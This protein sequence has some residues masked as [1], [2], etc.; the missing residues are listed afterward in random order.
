MTGETFDFMLTGTCLD[1]NSRNCMKCGFPSPSIC[2]MTEI[3]TP[4]CN[5]SEGQLYVP[6]DDISCT[7]NT[8]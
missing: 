2:R 3:L 8:I 1:E 6:H 4:K 5:I 7:S